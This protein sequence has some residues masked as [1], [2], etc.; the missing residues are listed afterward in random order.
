MLFSV[1]LLLE[2]VYVPIGKTS[3]SIVTVPATHT[4]VKDC[5]VPNVDPAVL[6]ISKTPGVPVLGDRLLFIIESEIDCN[7]RSTLWF[8]LNL[9]LFPPLSLL[10]IIDITIYHL[11][12]KIAKI[13]QL[14]KQMGRDGVKPPKS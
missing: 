13:I 2:K 1:P 9:L 5:Q 11:Y 3:P 4:N 8:Q 10:L 14:N 12:N 6:V 7:P